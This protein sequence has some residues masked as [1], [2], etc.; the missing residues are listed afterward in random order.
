MPGVE[1]RVIL[2]DSHLALYI[3][4]DLSK[5]TIRDFATR[6]MTQDIQRRAD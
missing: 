1:V 5:E 3:S 6:A 4:L 2:G